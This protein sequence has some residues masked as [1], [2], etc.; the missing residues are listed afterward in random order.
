MVARVLIPV[1]NQECTVSA[2]KSVMSRSWD[3]DT[4]FYLLKVVEDFSQLLYANEIVHSTAL[5]NEQEEY[6]YEMRMWLSDLTDSF[7]QVFPNTKSSIERGGVVQR[8]CEFAGEWCA[9]YIVIGSHDR[10]LSYRCAL[11]SV[12]ADVIKLAPCSVEVV[13]YRE[14]HKL[15]MQEGKITDEEIQAIVHPPYKVLVA[16][17][18]KPNIDAVIAWVGSIGWPENAQFKLIT[19]AEPP[20][21]AEISHWHRGIGTLYTKEGQHNKVIESHLH[22]LVAQLPET[23]RNNVESTLVRHELPATAIVEIANSWEADFVVLGA[24]PARDEFETDRVST[25]LEVSAGLHCSMA[26]VETTA[27]R[28]PSFGWRSIS[29]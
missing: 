14:L 20:H 21:K 5:S 4:E 23:M 25:P 13:R 1:D 11:S 3:K 15:L 22:N 6:T 8:I 2:L 16:V 26:V 29:E 24:S 10:M 9:D 18:E 7:C 19:V 17:D 27:E 28:Q 12:A